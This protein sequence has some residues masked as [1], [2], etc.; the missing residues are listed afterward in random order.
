MVSCRCGTKLCNSEPKEGYDDYFLFAC[1]FVLPIRVLYLCCVKVCFVLLKF[2]LV[3]YCLFFLV[4]F[5]T[6]AFVTVVF[7]I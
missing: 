2:V 7:L 4:W 6:G 5:Y 3:C 1:M